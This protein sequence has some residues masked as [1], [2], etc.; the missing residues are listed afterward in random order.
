[1]N[2]YSRMLIS[3]INISTKKYLENRLAAISYLLGS[4]SAL[5]ITLVTIESIFRFSRDFNGWN[6]GEVL[7][8]VGVSRMILAMFSLMFKKGID[9]LPEHVRKGELDP[10]LIKP[11]N[12]QFFI[13]FQHPRLIEVIDIMAGAVVFWYGLS[14]I[15]NTFSVFDVVLLIVNSF[16][17]LIIL[18]SIYFSLSCLAFWFDAFYSLGSMYYMISTPASLPTNIYDKSISF[19]ITYILPLAFIAFIPVTIFIHRDYKLLTLEALFA[20]ILFMLSNWIWNYSLRHYTSA[21]S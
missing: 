4:I 20:V 16:L 11:I 1:M 17:G 18:Y 7:I 6:R 2:R 3:L 15:Q 19:I 14:Q 13:T 12:T 21:S 8:V 10:L 5:I 9:V